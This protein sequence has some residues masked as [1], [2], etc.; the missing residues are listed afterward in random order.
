MEEKPKA[1]LAFSFIST[2]EQFKF[3][4]DYFRSPNSFL[5][6]FLDEFHYFGHAFRHQKYLNLAKFAMGKF[7]SYFYHSSYVTLKLIRPVLA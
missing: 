5:E 6:A 4:F 2:L 1:S 7:L 3:F